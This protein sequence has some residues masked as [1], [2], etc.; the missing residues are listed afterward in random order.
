MAV[1]VRPHPQNDEQWLRVD[2]SDLANCRSI[3]G[4]ARCRSTTASK[5]D[6]FDSI[7]H[8]AAVVGINTTAEI[9]SAIVGR[10]VFTMLAPEFR[11]TQEGTLH[12][13]H[14]ATP[15]EG[16]CTSRPIPGA[17]RATRRGAARTAPVTAGRCRRF[18]EAFVRPYGVDVAATP[19]LVEAIETVATRPPVAVIVRSPASRRTRATVHETPGEELRRD[20]EQWREA[21]TAQRT[22]RRLER[23][24]QKKQQR[25][26]LAKQ[27]REAGRGRG[28]RSLRP[29]SH[30]FRR[31]QL[32]TQD[33]GLDS[34]KPD[35]RR[36]TRCA[37]ARPAAAR[38]ASRSPGTVSPSCRRRAGASPSPQPSGLL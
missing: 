22:L 36:Q 9:E 25:K 23:K 34:A 29:W 32:T 18:V 11:D 30:E 38:P 31:P 5:A 3:H 10:Q 28:G 17:S 37:A 24:E 33:S 20:N 2:A 19:K 13:E 15:A 8:S 6:Y 12:F 1:L 35:V 7:Y 26:A 21:K 4:R 14:L 16:W 27:A